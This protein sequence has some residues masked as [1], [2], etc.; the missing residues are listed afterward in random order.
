MFKKLLPWY[1]FALVVLSLAFIYGC[2]S[3]P[4]SGGGGGGGG[5]ITGATYY[6]TQSGGDMWKWIITSTTEGRFYG[7]NFTATFELSGTYEVLPSL[8]RKAYINY[9]KKESMGPNV[10]DTAYFLE[11]PNTMLMVKPAGNSNSDKVIICAASA[12][13]APANGTICNLITIPWAGWLATSAAYGTVEVISGDTYTFEVVQQNLKGHVIAE[14]SS[15][16]SGFHFSNGMFSKPGDDMKIF[17]T[18]SGVFAG[19]AGPGRGGFAGASAEA[20]IATAQNAKDAVEGRIFRGVM[21]NYDPA[22]NTGETQAIGATGEVGGI[23][24]GS[25]FTGLDIETSAEPDYLSHMATLEFTD[26]ISPGMVRGTLDTGSDVNNFV[27]VVA[28]VG[29]TQKLAVIGIT[30]QEGSGRPQN[31][32]VIEQ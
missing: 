10:G 7:H 9:V 15:A 29:D 16:Q 25:D 31:F 6:G 28:H 4:T 13:S 11:F 14:S 22:E 19:D 21:F 32:I 20:G 3:A 1:L 12:T 2:G 27:L 5:G 26:A 18:P 23:I 17:I 8:F 30:T 24:H